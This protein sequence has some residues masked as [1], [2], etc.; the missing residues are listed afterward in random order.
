M[1]ENLTEAFAIKATSKETGE[2]HYVKV[3]RDCKTFK[4]VKLKID[5]T[6]YDTYD[7]AE[8]AIKK[9]CDGTNTHNYA[10]CKVSELELL[11]GALRH[12]GVL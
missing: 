2:S 10:V 4:L 11:L 3:K 1:A 7:E 9:H 5:G 6:F 12:G 8:E